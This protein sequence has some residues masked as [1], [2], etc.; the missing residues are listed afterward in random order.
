[1]DKHVHVTSHCAALTSIKLNIN[2]ID[3]RLNTG[4]NIV[5]EHV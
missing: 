4:C 3:L 2:A 5:P 1:M